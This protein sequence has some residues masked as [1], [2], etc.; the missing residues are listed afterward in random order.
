M[1]KVVLPTSV[2]HNGADLSD[3]VTFRS[4]DTSR[5]DSVGGE[6]RS[7]AA[8][9]RRAIVGPDRST[10]IDVAITAISQTDL[11]RLLALNGSTVLYRDGWGHLEWCYLASVSKS[12][13]VMLGSQVAHN[14]RLRLETVDAP[15]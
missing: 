8:G 9:N 10:T 2:I 5:S 4:L 15:T 1:V 13:D 6:V 14:A 7:F 3:M 11:R 12:D